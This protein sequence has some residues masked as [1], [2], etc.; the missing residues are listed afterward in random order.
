MILLCRDSK[1]E[2]N[3]VTYECLYN[4]LDA[5]AFGKTERKIRTSFYVVIIILHYFVADQ[6]NPTLKQS[7]L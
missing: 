5:Q 3:N 4:T 7:C 2:P 6:A 1:S